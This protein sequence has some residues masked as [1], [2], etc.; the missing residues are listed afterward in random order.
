MLVPLIGF[1]QGDSI[2]LLVLAH[3]DMT[4]EQVADKLRQSARVRVDIEGPWRLRVGDCTP[5]PSSTVAEA[6]LRPL[7]RIDL[8][9]GLR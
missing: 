2:G 9:R 8:R 7:Q 1:V 4:I 6:G 5:S 3:D